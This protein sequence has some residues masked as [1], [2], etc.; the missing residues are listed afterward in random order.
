VSRAG[1]AWGIPMPDDPQSV[2][3]VWVDALINYIS[4]VGY[5]TDD[6]LRERWW[7]ANLHVIGKD[8][9]RFHASSGPRC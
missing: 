5:G 7:P 6:T 8:I 1:Q 9:T 4:A 2:I 3:Y